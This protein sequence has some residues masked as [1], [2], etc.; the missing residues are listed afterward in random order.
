MSD[1]RDPI[2]PGEILAEELEEIGMT[3]VELARRIDVPDNRIYQIVHGKRSI[4]A[5]T[6]LRLGKF[7]NTTAEYWLNLQNLYELDVARQEA[8]S[9]LDLIQPFRPSQA[10][11]TA[12]VS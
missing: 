8:S 6:A 9:T 1:W 5:D 12:F 2:H 11:H 10:T 7:F 4:T 3:A